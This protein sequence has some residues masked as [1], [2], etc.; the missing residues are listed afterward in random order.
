V[1]SAVCR[2]QELEASADGSYQILEGSHLDDA[3]C[4]WS[5]YADESVSEAVLV[6]LQHK[7][8]QCKQ[9]REELKAAHDRLTV[10]HSSVAGQIA[11][12]ADVSAHSKTGLQQTVEQIQVDNSNVSVICTVHC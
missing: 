2:Y 8:Q 11:Q 3:L 1:T 10:H 12:L 4:T 7:L 5:Q 6:Q 9:R